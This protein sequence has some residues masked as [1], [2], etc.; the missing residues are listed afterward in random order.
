MERQ[1][2]N[3]LEQQVDMDIP[4]GEI[5]KV[6]IKCSATLATVRGIYNYEIIK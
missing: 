6:A 2:P 3:Y 1:A 5:F 4:I